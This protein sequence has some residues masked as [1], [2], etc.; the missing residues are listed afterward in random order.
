MSRLPR[1]SHA[2][3][4]WLLLAKTGRLSRPPRLKGY[5]GSGLYPF[6]LRPGGSPACSLRGSSELAAL[7]PRLLAHATAAHAFPEGF[8]A[9]GVTL[10]TSMDCRAAACYTYERERGVKLKR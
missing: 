4:P 9:H 8:G 6:F 3:E 2:G 5:L 1:R 10:K 7:H